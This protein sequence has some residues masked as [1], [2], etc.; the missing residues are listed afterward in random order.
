MIAVLV[1]KIKIKSTHRAER[2]IVQV[3][4]A[5]EFFHNKYAEGSATGAATGAATPRDERLEYSC[6]ASA[7]ATVARPEVRAA[8]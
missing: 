5:W 4:R 3:K 6:N 8:D 1:N 7:N 2:R